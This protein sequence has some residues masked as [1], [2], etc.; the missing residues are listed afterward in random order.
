MKRCR[1]IQKDMERYL[2]KELLPEKIHAFED[3]LR[4]CV[5]CRKVLEEKREQRR[6]RI[7]A[8]VPNEI[9]ITEEEI[10]RTVQGEWSPEVSISTPLKLKIPWWRRL[11]TLTFKPLP[12]IAFAVC[13]IALGLSLFLPFGSRIHQ[14]RG[15]IIEEI[16]STHSFMIYRP[17]HTETTLI[18][19]VPIRKGNK[20]AT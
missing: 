19:I 4:T 12:A 18:W 13:L 1:K 8:L 7:E 20:E 9:P 2:D 15:I 10:L 14:E 16:E 17:Q 5:R 11:K 6:L 3:H